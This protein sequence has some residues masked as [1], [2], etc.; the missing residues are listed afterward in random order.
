M[1]TDRLLDLDAIRVRLAEERAIG[2]MLILNDVEDLIAEIE[3]LRALPDSCA[4]LE[5]QRRQLEALGLLG[6]FAPSV[7]IADALGDEILRLRARHEAELAARDFQITTL[8]DSCSAY[9]QQIADLKAD[10]EEPTFILRARDPLAPVLVRLWADLASQTNTDPE[11]VT[12]AMACAHAMTI[13]R[14]EHGSIQQS[15]IAAGEPV[16]QRE[17]PD[18][19]LFRRG[20]LA[21][22][23]AA[24]ID[25]L[26]AAVR[27]REREIAANAQRNAITPQAGDP[28][29]LP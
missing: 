4:C 25:E 22:V 20:W 14:Q 21:A 12:K 8:E 23:Q 26:I 6:E 16:S 15:A 9:E 17:T 29:S 11:R 2:P 28:T 27:D 3:R 10:P 7:D 19:D 24:P 13:W 18:P 1:T 5:N